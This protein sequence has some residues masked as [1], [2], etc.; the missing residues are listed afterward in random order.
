MKFCLACSKA[1]Q[2]CIGAVWEGGEGLNRVPMGESMGLVRELVGEMRGFR[3]EWQEMKEVVGQG[4]KNIVKTN[5][6]WHWT[7]FT[8]ALN[9]V[10]WWVGFPQEE[11]KQEYQELWK[12][13][14][15]YWEYLKGKIDREELDEL[16]IG[17]YKDYELEGG[18]EEVGFEVELEE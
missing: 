10:E 3:E 11:M 16:V 4:L 8:D 6:S 1:K 17:R 15:T 18:R 9:Y 2:K 14:G 7:P 12:E 5:H 13:D